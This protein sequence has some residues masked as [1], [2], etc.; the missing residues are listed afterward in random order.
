[1][2]KFELDPTIQ[3]ILNIK[4]VEVL[5]D[6]LYKEELIT[7]KEHELLIKKCE[8]ELK[9]KIKEMEVLNGKENKD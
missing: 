9:K 1:M 3:E 4:Y 8:K 7:T 6:K 5:M 2:N